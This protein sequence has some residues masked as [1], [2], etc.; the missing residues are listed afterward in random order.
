MA[1][2]M[3]CGPE[4]VLYGSGMANTSSATGS[5]MWL[6]ASHGWYSYI[7]PCRD[8]LP[9]TFGPAMGGGMAPAIVKILHKV[10]TELRKT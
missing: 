5:R 4:P 3:A 2:G 7:E 6:A 10:L 8:K 1:D 9:A